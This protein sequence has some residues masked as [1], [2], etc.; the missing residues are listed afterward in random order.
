MEKRG[1][2]FPL[3]QFADAVIRQNI[4]QD[5]TPIITFVAKKTSLITVNLFIA[6]VLCSALFA[7]LVSNC[8]AY[9]VVTI[10]NSA[11]T[12]LEKEFIASTTNQFQATTIINPFFQ[13]TYQVELNGH[14][15]LFNPAPTN[16]DLLNAL[17]TVDSNT[18]VYGFADGMSYQ[19]IVNENMV[20]DF[21]VNCSSP[22]YFE[23]VQ[24]S[25]ETFNKKTCMDVAA[26]IY[27][28]MFQASLSTPTTIPPVP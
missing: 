20:A 13:G 1:N 22:T 21:Y 6:G 27:D 8:Q 14:N 23:L 9:T 10:S 15:P 11:P 4:T 17:V 5:M 25:S 18:F 26:S 2:S 7:G 12:G 28:A 3:H 16:L 24:V 19:Q